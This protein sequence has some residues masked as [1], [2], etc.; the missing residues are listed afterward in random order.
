[1]TLVHWPSLPAVLPQ[2]SVRFQEQ[3]N[4]QNSSLGLVSYEDVAVNFTWEEWQD[5]D[6]AQRTL[7]RVVMLETYSSLVSLGHC[8]TKPEVIVKLEQGAEPWTVEEPLEQSLPD[9]QTAGDLMET[10]QEYQ[11]RLLWQ[12]GLANYET[13]MKERTSLGKTLNLSAA[14]VSKLIINNGSYSGVKPK[15]CNVCQN[16]FLPGEPGGMRVGE[17][18]KECHTT[19]SPLRCA[20]CPSCHPRNQTLQQPLEFSGQ[21]KDFNKGATLCT[22]RRAHMGETAYR[23]NEHREACGKSAVTAQERTHI[24][25]NHCGCNKWR[26]TFCEKPTQLHLGLADFEEQRHKHDQSGGNFSKT[27]HLAQLS[28]TPLEEKTFECDVCAKTFYKRSNLSKHRKIHTGEK[29]Y[30]CSECEKTFIS[31]TVLTVHR[32]THTGEKPYAC[33]ECEKSFCHK[34]HLTVHQR[35]HT[36][37]KPYECY[38]CGKSFPVKTK[39]TVHLRTHT[40][41]KPYECNECRKT[42]YE[43]SALTAHQRTHTGEKLHECKECRKAFCGKSALTVHQRTHTGEKPYE[44][45]ECWKSFCRRSALAV[46]Q[47]THTGEKPYGCN[48]C[49]KAFCQKSHLG[50]HQ[51]THTGEKSCMAET[52]SV[53]SKTHF[54]FL[55]AHS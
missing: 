31:K 10:G 35:I 42:F 47:R 53:F 48:E 22:Y 37:E 9:V 43:K 24:G 49:G 30:K 1:M 6:D 3:Q 36:G 32:R 11:S 2:S 52:G 39:L 14:D 20:E 41:E 17:N 8:I 25:E 21:A 50:K 38:E 26:N 55:L 46:H 19:G 40:G 44:C 34:S 51:R 23:Y 16:T 4:M 12:V 28:R 5:L 27:S 18:A 7:Y 45:K 54:L 29:P 33:V 13:S 15:L